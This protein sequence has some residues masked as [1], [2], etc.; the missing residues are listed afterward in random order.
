MRGSMAVALAAVLSAGCTS[1]SG[2]LDTRLVDAQNAA[3]GPTGR[4][5]AAITDGRGH[6]AKVRTGEARV[7]W[8]CAWASERAAHDALI[9]TDEAGEL[10]AWRDWYHALSE[11]SS[12]GWFSEADWSA[13]GRDMVEK[14]APLLDPDADAAALAASLSSATKWP[15]NSRGSQRTATFDWQNQAYS[16]PGEGQPQESPFFSVAR[17]KSKPGGVR[18]LTAGSALP[19]LGGT[20]DALK[21]WCASVGGRLSDGGG[22]LGAGARASCW[23]PGGAKGAEV[24]TF[25][26]E[27]SVWQVQWRGEVPEVLKDPALLKPGLIRD[28][29]AWAVGAGAGDLTVIDSQVVRVQRLQASDGPVTEITLGIKAGE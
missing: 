26:D 28:A 15:S 19:E 16:S 10:L 13:E 8:R 21:T 14:L 12:S 2:A 17:T 22:M 24:A 27:P 11:S 18:W 1:T 4:A 20:R 25:G 29:V 9:V 5:M 3:P 6:C 23:S 7:E